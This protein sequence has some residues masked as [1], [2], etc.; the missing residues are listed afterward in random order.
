MRIAPALAAILLAQ[1]APAAELRVTGFGGSSNWTLFA[2]EE[3]GFFAREGLAVRFT[4]SR[5]SSSELAELAAGEVDVALT[6]M[7]NVAACREGEGE[8]AC[9]KPVA[10]VAILAV[11]RGARFNLIAAPGVDSVAAL[12]GKALAVD[13]AASG[14]VFV[15]R[16][17]LAAAGLGRDDYRLVRAGGSRERWRA[18]HDGRVDATLLNAPYDAE[19]EGEGFRRIANSADVAPRYQGSVAAVRIEWARDHASALR[20]FARAWIAAADWLADPANAIEAKALLRRHVERM[21]AAQADRSYADLLDPANGTLS[22]RGAMD[23][24]GVRTVLRLRRRHAPG[25]RAVEDPARYY[26][27]AYYESAS[28]R[29]Q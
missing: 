10:V 4:A 7:D 26:D 3:R 14:Y 28:A 24:E 8:G 21:S 27:A 13:S 20:A 11:N 18:L 5:D 6:A 15:L 17:M 12:K 22:P 1:A 2:A 29:A 25:T 9:A 19:A 23:I 16:E